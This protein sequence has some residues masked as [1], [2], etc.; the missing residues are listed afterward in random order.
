MTDLQSRLDPQ[1]QADIRR[2]LVAHATPQPAVT[3]NRRIALA[4][5]FAAVLAAT[6]AIVVTVYP[7]PPPPNYAAWT[8]IPQA[9]PP[10][11]APDDDIERWASKCTDLGVGGVGIEGVPARPK[12]AA[13]RDVLVDRRGGFTFCVDVSLGSGTPADPLIALSGLK[14]DGHN[15]LNS[16]AATVSDKPFTRPQA[17]AVLVLGGT[18]DAPPEDGTSE[19]QAFQLYGLSGPAVVNVDLVL[20]NGLRVTATLRHGVWGVWWPSDRGDPTGG[21]LEVRTATGVTTVDPS[22]VRLPIE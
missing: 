21:K 11:T 22:T 6:G 20:T 1:R 14:A 15:G 18:V 19:I 17:D 10:M 4:G 13:G 3:R 9:A 2:M 12:A 7:D 8:A 16:M 5:A